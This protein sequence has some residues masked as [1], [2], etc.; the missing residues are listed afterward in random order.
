MKKCVYTNP[1]VLE[2]GC[3]CSF[4]TV[5][6]DRKGREIVDMNFMTKGGPR[7]VD[8]LST[9]LPVPCPIPTH[10]HRVGVH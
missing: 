7:A 1:A 4:L 2:S 9:G 5:G 10:L 8:T 3:A 6:M